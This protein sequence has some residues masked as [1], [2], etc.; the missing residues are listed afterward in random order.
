MKQN[1]DKLT[2]LLELF[3]AGQTTNAQERELIE[4]FKKG[5]VPP[6]L[7]Q[8]R[9]MLMWLDEGMPSV[10]TPQA[11][12]RRWSRQA[13]IACLGAAASLAMI[14][15]VA[16]SFMSRR[17]GTLEREDYVTY[18]GSYVI[19]DGKKITDLDEIMPEL[20]RAEQIVEQQVATA[21]SIESMSEYINTDN[22]AVQAALES[23]LSY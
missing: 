1:D 23:A 12:P 22:P 18:A 14:V 7:E 10:D 3:M 19:R 4:R 20:Q 11:K 15:T 17:H 6:A 21:G 9:P 8:Y 16:L 2:R 5:T 13:I